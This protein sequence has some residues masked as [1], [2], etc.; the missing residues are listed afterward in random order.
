MSTNRKNTNAW[1]IPSMETYLTSIMIRKKR[2]LLKGPFILAWNLFNSNLS[3]L[4]LSCNFDVEKNSPCV[5]EN[6]Q[7]DVIGLVL[8]ENCKSKQVTDFIA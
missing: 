2:H 1:G 3:V 8:R 6:I 5:Y 7:N 4:I